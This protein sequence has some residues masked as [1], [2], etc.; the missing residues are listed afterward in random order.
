MKSSF[1]NPATLA[2]LKKQFR[3]LVLANHPDRGGSTEKMQAINEEFG[4][5]YKSLEFKKETVKSN[6]GYEDDYAGSTAYEYSQHVYNEYGWKGERYNSSL[7]MSDLTDIFRKWLKK[8]Y[9][10][11]RFTVNKDYASISVHIMTTDFNP[12]SVGEPP[13]RYDVNI[14]HFGKD[15]KLNDRAKDIINNITA[16]VNSYNYD[17]SDVMTDYF[18]RGFY[19]KL[20]F[21][22]K[23]TA[24][25]V[26]IPRARRTGGVADPDF[27][28][29]V[30]PA[31]AGIKKALGRAYFDKYTYRGV[32]MLVLGEDQIYFNE[33]DFYPLSYAGYKTAKKRFENLTSAG[34]V[35]EIVNRG[36]YVI[37]FIGY[38]A[39]VAKLLSEEDA[40]ANAAEKAWS[41]KK[42]KSAK[43]SENEIPNK[44]ADA[45]DTAA[46]ASKS[47]KKTEKVEAGGATGAVG[48]LEIVDYSEKS[49]A[50]FGDT[51][52]IKGK[53]KSLG[54]RF[55]KFLAYG[56]ERRAGWV[57]QKSKRSELE[58]ICKQYDNKVSSEATQATETTEAM[59]TAGQPLRENVDQQ[60]I[61]PAD[62][63]GPANGIADQPG[64]EPAQAPGRK[65]MDDSAY[66]SFVK[67]L[68]SRMSEAGYRGARNYAKGM[69]ERFSLRIDQV[70]YVA[71]LLAEYRLRNYASQ[72]TG[73]A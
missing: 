64:R 28:R 2:E 23:N 35:C 58:A 54:A 70:R 26:N 32:E 6:T 45:S 51:K 13:M 7:G 15:V 34:I 14:F 57:L 43:K 33:K 39:D 38:T 27:I 56:S 44:A 5:L 55:N 41:E 65:R 31:H 40:A 9:P 60:L 67:V 63:P 71:F 19:F 16:Y 37:R 53:L 52:L 4:K 17:N 3:I 30:G 18:D 59:D 50:V 73:A 1:N 36:N 47:A 11:C 42:S 68:H 20:E 12:F 69:L 49:V 48:T 22:S 61:Q 8:T 62:Q 25:A 10:G 21:G 24:F 66:M 29:P 72:H 46:P